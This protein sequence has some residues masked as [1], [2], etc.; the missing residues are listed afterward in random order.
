MFFLV[1]VFLTLLLDVENERRRLASEPELDDFPI[2]PKTF[3]AVNTVQSLITC[4][5]EAQIDN[6]SNSDY[7]ETFKNSIAKIK[8]HR[9]LDCEE[10]GRRLE[11][12]GKRFIQYY[13]GYFI[14]YQNLNN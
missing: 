7:R 13:Y 5:Y 1:V 3:Y 8:I 14:K 11:G 10:H 12:I 4:I 2:S 9:D 6:C